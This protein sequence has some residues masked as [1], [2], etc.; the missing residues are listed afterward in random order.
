VHPIAC[1]AAGPP[2]HIVSGDQFG[3]VP[4]KNIRG[5][6]NTGLLLWH[7]PGMDHTA[8]MWCLTEL[9]TSA[10]HKVKDKPTGWFM[11]VDT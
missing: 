10:F 8:C 4:T 2:Q 6:L 5:V 1:H 7:Q 9:G 11:G 3:S